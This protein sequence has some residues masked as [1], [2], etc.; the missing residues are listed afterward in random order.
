VGHYQNQVV[1]SQVENLERSVTEV[2]VVV[3]GAENHPAV[4]VEPD[5]PEAGCLGCLR[6]EVAE[7]C[8]EEMAGTQRMVEAVAVVHLVK[9]SLT[10]PQIGLEEQKQRTR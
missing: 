2:V 4:A 9:E 6:G 5:M 3:V 1:H 10:E 8:Q 7:A